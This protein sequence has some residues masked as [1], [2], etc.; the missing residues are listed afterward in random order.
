L[1]SIHIKTNC[2][3]T[4][5][6]SIGYAE[7]GEGGRGSLLIRPVSVSKS[8]SK[9]GRLFLYDAPTGANY[10]R[11]RRRFG[12]W[13]GNSIVGLARNSGMASDA[14]R[15]FKTGSYTVRRRYIQNAHSAPSSPAPAMSSAVKDL[16]LPLK[17]SMRRYFLASDDPGAFD[18]SSLD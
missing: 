8:L 14:V 6:F 17:I 9:R 1:F 12:G 15:V 10:L 4:C 16:R 13:A 5:V 11:W 7:N 3:L 18:F 2:R